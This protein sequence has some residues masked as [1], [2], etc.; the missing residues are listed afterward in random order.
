LPY[1]DTGAKDGSANRG[2]SGGTAINTIAKIAE[3]RP[4]APR[5]RDADRTR[6]AILRSATREFGAHGFSGART[7][8]IAA[9]AKC[10]IRLLYHHFGS[11]QA[12]Y[13][14]VIEAAYADLRTKEAALR[15]D[16]ADPLGCVEQLLRFTFTYFERHPHFEGLLRAEN[17]MQGRFVRQSRTV[18]EAADRLK[19]TLSTIIAAGEAQGVFRPGIDPVQL[20]VTIT[21]LSRFH[22]SN[23]YSLSA[24][25]GVD[26][27]STAWR[28]ARL[29]HSVE[30]LR[31]WVERT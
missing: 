4:A 6:A 22:L 20:Y 23:S 5:K 1:C 7:E 31:A 3:N 16:L 13:L 28:A 26:L 9:Q 10:N 24:L 30:L 18:P 12:L 15:F 2:L 27:K 29:D 19:A 21:A 14:A 17:M 25:L 11:K 8:R